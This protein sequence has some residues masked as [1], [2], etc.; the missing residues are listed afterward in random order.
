MDTRMR[1]AISGD[2]ALGLQYLMLDDDWVE[3]V[4]PVRSY[5]VLPPGF[6]DSARQFIRDNAARL[7]E[8]P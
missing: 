4:L 8:F 1:A 3:L 5:K 7:Y 6:H 2:G